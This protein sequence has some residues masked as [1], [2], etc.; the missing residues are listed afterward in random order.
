MLKILAGTQENALMGSIITAVFVL[1]VSM[2]KTVKQILMTAN[3]ITAKIIQHVLMVP[4][5]IFAYAMKVG[6]ESSAHQTSMI[7]MIICIMRQCDTTSQILYYFKYST[8]C[9]ELSFWF[10][11]IH[12]LNIYDH[13]IF[14]RETPAYKRVN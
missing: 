10:F 7:V 3:R 14:P 12:V 1:P 8:F 4:I 9:G 5:H 13:F 2:V 6:K 11:L